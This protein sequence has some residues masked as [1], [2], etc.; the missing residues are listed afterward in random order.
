MP[1]NQTY[2][3][4]QLNEIIERH[5]LWLDGDAHGA[6]ANFHRAKLANLDFS[7]M[8]LQSLDMSRAWLHGAQFNRTVIKD[9]NLRGAHL[10]DASLRSASLRDVNL[11]HANAQ[12]DFTSARL[13]R[14]NFTL[15]AMR[16]AKL[17]HLGS[18]Y[19][20]VGNGREIK[21]IHTDIWPVVYTAHQMQIGCQ[22][23]SL[24]D[25]WSFDDDVIH[26]MD[27]RAVDWWMVWKPILQQ[28]IKIS[29][30][31]CGSCLY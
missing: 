20:T 12:A 29:P 4:E 15:A 27:P 26:A 14:V 28:I 24:D 31:G 1:S 6:Q 22:L 9:V 8:L 2:T 19:E 3:Q 17:G 23:H 16:G 18:L 7:G 13:H 10:F 25:W 30:G 21:S 5:N 11:F